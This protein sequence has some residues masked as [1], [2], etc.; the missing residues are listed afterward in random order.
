MLFER[1]RSEFSGLE[2]GFMRI[3]GVI[4]ARLGS[5]R[6]KH[7][8]LQPLLGRPLI[9]WTCEA[10]SQSQKLDDFIVATDSEEIVHKVEKWGYKAQMTSPHCASGTDRVFEVSQKFQPDIILNI[11]G[12]EPLIP[13]QEIDGLIDFYSF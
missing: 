6:L 1:E 7:K 5:V 4:P 12:D 9:Q 2:R 8:P 11:Q 13:A 3:L 10:V